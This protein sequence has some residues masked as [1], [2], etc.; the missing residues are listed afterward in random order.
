MYFDLEP[1]LK[2]KLIEELDVIV[3]INLDDDQKIRIIPK[4]EIKEKIGRSPDV[5]DMV[6]MRCYFELV[7]T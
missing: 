5:S 6:M 3:Q 4:D 7:F 1:D 2:D